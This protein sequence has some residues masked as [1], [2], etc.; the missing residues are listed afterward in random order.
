MNPS[1]TILTEPRPAQPGKA[2]KIKEAVLKPVRYYLKNKITRP[3]KKFG[4]HESVTRSLVEG[5]QKTGA[6]FN[7]NPEQETEIHEN[8]IHLSGVGQL[9]GTLELKKRGIIKL[10]LAGPNVVDHVLDHDQIIANPLID[11]FVVPSEWVKKLVLKDCPALEG[12]ILIWPAGIDTEYWKPRRRLSGKR[13]LIYHKTEPT[14]FYEDVVS[15]IN[16]MGYETDT[17]VYGNY[18][19][20]Q[21][22]RKLGSAVFAV[23]ISRSESQGIALAESWSMNVPT[24]VYNPGN[25]LYRGIKE[26]ASAAPYLTDRTGYEWQDI[27]GLSNGI[28]YMLANM[29]TFRPRE[30]VLE[31]FSDEKCAQDLLNSI[32]KYRRQ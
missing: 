10:L 27:A 7:Y 25:F 2:R 20:S 13:V 14:E 21:F 4:G 12:R 22:K 6:T 8:A 29:E 24:L 23:F 3:F 32:M 1:L 16:K 18:E 9:S 11:Y 19:P 17:V 28:N 30:Y 15:I 26:D 31:R 5:L